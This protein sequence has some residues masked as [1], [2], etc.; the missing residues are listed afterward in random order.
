MPGAEGLRLPV[1]PRS[2]EDYSMALEQAGFQSRSEAVYPT[3]QILSAKPGLRQAGHVPIALL[4]Q[5]AKGGSS[6]TP[7]KE[8]NGREDPQETRPVR[9][10][11][12]SEKVK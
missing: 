9:P 7:A 4:L 1:V 11:L 8:C 6:P 5:G 2:S 12:A 3:A 10:D